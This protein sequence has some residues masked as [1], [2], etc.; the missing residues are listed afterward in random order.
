ML[1]RIGNLVL[2]SL[3]LFLVLFIALAINWPDNWGL[4]SPPTPRP[5]ADPRPFYVTVVA[6]TICVSV[7]WIWVISA[8]FLFA[9]RRFAWYGSMLGVASAIGLL[10]GIFINAEWESVF[11]SRVGEYSS[12]A[13][14]AIGMIFGF[15]FLISWMT[16]SVAVFIGLI[17]NRK[18]LV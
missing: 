10:A 16:F 8:A 13:S 15:G 12:F 3:F 11:S 5:L 1:T 9:R 6:W 14:Y 2:A 17:K 4:L 18:E 7:I